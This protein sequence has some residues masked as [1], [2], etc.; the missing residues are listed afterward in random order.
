MS[1]AKGVAWQSRPNQTLTWDELKFVDLGDFIQVTGLLE[2]TQAG[3]VTVF[4]N[5]IVLLS[6]AL[7]PY[8]N[9][10]EDKDERYRRRYVDM[11][12]H[13]KVREVIKRK[14]TF[15]QTIRKTLVDRGF[16]EVFLPVL[17]HTTGGADAK[18]FITHHNTL[19]EDLYLRISLELYSKRA[20]GAGFEKVFAIGPVFRNEGMSDEHAN[21]FNHVEWYWAYADYRDQMELTKQ[22]IIETAQAVY[23]TTKFTTRGHSFDLADTWKE[24]DYTKVIRDTYGIDIFTDTDDRI[25]KVALSH[26]IDLEGGAVNRQRMIDSLWKLVRKTISGPAFLIHEPAFMSPLAK[27]KT[28]NPLVTE[29]FHII[30]AGTEAAN[31]YSEINDPQYQLQQFLDQQKMRD[32]GDDEA[33]MLDIDFIEMLE[34]GM[35]P[36]TGLGFS[37]R[38]FWFFEDITARE[39]AMFPILRNEVDALTRKIYPF[40]EIQRV[41]GKSEN[42]APN[43][44]KISNNTVPD[45]VIPRES[46]VIPPGVAYGQSPAKAGITHPTNLALHITRDQALALI[47]EHIKNPGLRKHCLAVEAAMG[48]LYNHFT[49]SHP[50]L[51]EG[52]HKDIWTL[53]GLLHDADWEECREM[54][55]Q[56]TL[57]TLT[58]LRGIGVEHNELI[59][60]ILTHAHHVTSY[61]Q[62]ESKLEW[63]LYCCDELTGLIVANA[64][65]L[66]SKK[67][68]DVTVESVIKKMGSKSFAAAIDRE[69]I[70]MCEEKLGIKL[71]EFVGIVLRGMQTSASTLGL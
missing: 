34:Y 46:S 8:P 18:P 59:D 65:I 50:E 62:P 42:V 69:G 20:I 56:H 57:K 23:G 35:P 58:W 64:L 27:A 15:W 29:R 25:Q 41:K 55:T 70:K 48:G 3:E 10:I 26:G 32:G 40:L 63:S 61:R 2:R 52:S 19:D 51:V 37:E 4:A 16:T 45:P 49:A 22:V 44:P 14:A 36:T 13:P 1:D 67:L 12:L 7:R 31:G 30:L 71:E 60:A 39:G 43:V 17:E 28:D 68:A 21:E 53:T 54:P 11:V 38:L 24:I 33:Q 5:E 47:D 9:Q 6:K 66:P